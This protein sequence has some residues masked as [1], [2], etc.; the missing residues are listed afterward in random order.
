MSLLRAADWA[1]GWIDE[2]IDISYNPLTR[3][4]ARRM[5]ETGVLNDDEFFDAMRDIGYNDTNAAR[6]LEWV[7][8]QS[9]GADKDL[10]QSVVMKGYKLGLISRAETKHY[11]TSFGYDDDEAE[12]LLGIEDRKDEQQ[13]IEDAIKVAQWEYARW[14]ITESS[15]IEKLSKLDIPT[16]KAKL[17]LIKA[18]Q[19]R[20]KRAK[21]PA[22]EDVKGW[23]S[24]KL[25]T[26]SEA[27]KYLTRMGYKAAE[28]DLYIKG[29]RA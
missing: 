28:R 24:K 11:L 21:L 3:V 26:E 15:F 14:E 12:L 13:A 27:G 5:W 25:I 17:Y 29:W 2:L 19:D 6:Y 20:T 18:D 9:Q 22:K 4:D 16:E 10:S 23:L 1:P 8:A 7:K